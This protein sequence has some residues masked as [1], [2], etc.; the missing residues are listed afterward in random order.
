MKVG[1]TS[2]GNRDFFLEWVVNSK[3]VRAGI[4]LIQHCARLVSL[5]VKAGNQKAHYTAPFNN[6]FWLRIYTW[7]LANLW[8]MDQ[9]HSLRVESFTLE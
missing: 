5:S 6:F 7:S 3:I 9:G 2:S 4:L 8:V 1:R